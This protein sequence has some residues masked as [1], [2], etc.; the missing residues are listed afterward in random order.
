MNVEVLKT[1]LARAEDA[2][3]QSDD[4]LRALPDLFAKVC[5]PDSH[6]SP[7]DYARSVTSLLALNERL[8]QR[9]KDLRSELRKAEMDAR[10][11][12]RPAQSQIA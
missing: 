8:H 4:Q 9:A 2:V 7:A 12:Q 6:L 11:A 3:V 10:T 5:A 1:E